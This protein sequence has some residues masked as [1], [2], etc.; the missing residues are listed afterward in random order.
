MALER[1]TVKKLFSLSP[2][3]FDEYHNSLKH[4]LPKAEIK[5]IPAND[6]YSLTF[7]NVVWLKAFIQNTTFENF[8]KAYQM[9]FGID[10]SEFLKCDVVE[11]YQSF[12]WIQ[13]QMLD[14]IDGEKRLD[15]DIE[16]ELKEAG[17]DELNIFGEL[18]TLITIG[19]EFGKSPAEIEQWSYSMVFA[20]SL[21][22][23]ISSGINKRHSKI[24]SKKN[25]NG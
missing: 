17:I 16:P 22:N 7:S 15:S 6:I 23:N 18:N 3:R 9:I 5:S 12:N 4:V 20:L 8:V 14:L 10:K 11:F 13:N 2:E 21:H 25:G 24:L 19:K 1:I